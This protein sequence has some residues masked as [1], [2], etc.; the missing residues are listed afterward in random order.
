MKAYPDKRCW[1][2]HFKEGELVLVKLQPYR[3]YSLALR[4]NQVRKKIF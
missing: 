4:M 1:D 3:E 2:L